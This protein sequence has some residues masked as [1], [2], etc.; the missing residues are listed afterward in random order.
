MQKVWWGTSLRK[1]YLDHAL[2]WVSGVLDS[3][4]RTGTL[5]C[6]WVW[7]DLLL[8]NRPYLRRVLKLLSEDLNFVEVRIHT[9]IAVP[10]VAFEMRH[11]ARSEDIGKFCCHFPCLCKIFRSVGVPSRN[12]GDIFRIGS[13]ESARS[14]WYA[15]NLFEVIVLQD[16]DRRVFVI[17][18]GNNP[19][20]GLLYWWYIGFDEI[21]ALDE[22]TFAVLD[23]VVLAEGLVSQIYLFSSATY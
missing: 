6:C 3:A 8:E 19:F 20:Q 14:V 4:L 13:N 15:Q 23:Y 2:L 1:H 17:W 9:I 16:E 7:L 5:P 12:G 11:L 22:S 10:S 18:K 21:W